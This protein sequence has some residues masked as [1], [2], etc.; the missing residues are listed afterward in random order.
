MTNEDTNAGGPVLVPLCNIDFEVD[1]VFGIGTSPFG[2]SRIGYITGGAFTGARMSGRVLPGGGN[3]SRSG[4]LGAD[5]SVGS[6]DARAVLQTHDGA[7]IYLSYTGRTRI[8]DAVRTRFAAPDAGASVD[9]A[10]YYLR[11]AVVFETAA[12]EYA[13]LNGIVALSMGR[14]TERGVHHRMFEVT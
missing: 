7:L 6:F 14:K 5:T 3:W 9:P 8:T 2:D 13:W 12:P 11:I 1:G 10:D 4:R